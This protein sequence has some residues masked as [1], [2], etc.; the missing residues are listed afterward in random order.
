MILVTGATGKTGGATL[1]ALTKLGAP[2]RALVRD[3]NKWHVPE[4][5]EVA[6]GHFE[7]PASLDAALQGVEKAY[8]V[9]A[10]TEQQ[11]EQ[12]SAFVAAARRAGVR[13]LV[14]LSV[15]GADQPGVGAMRFAA[16]HQILERVVRESG[17]PWTF[18]RPNGFMQNYL[19]QAQSLAQQGVFYSSLSPAAKVSHID[20]LDIGAVAAKTLTEPGHEGQ[21]YTLTGPEPL[22]DDDIA[23]R[24]STVLGRPIKHIQVPL[25]GTRETMLANG[26]PAWNVDGLAELW[27]LYETGAAAGVAPDVERLLGHPARSFEDFVRDH[28]T[29][30]G[31]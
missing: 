5:V 13:H 8:L 23:A 24:F 1:Q 27:A 20:A 7:D 26:F 12:E 25:A 16:Y 9:G 19:G 18:L 15:I 14:R 30:F 10:S 28:L 6:V 3:P 29:T 2:V 11:V 22:S 17:L 21:A 31:G 4:G